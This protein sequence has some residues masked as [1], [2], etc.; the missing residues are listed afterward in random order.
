[1]NLWLIKKFIVAQSNMK[2]QWEKE[3]MAHVQKKQNSNA[4]QKPEIVTQKIKHIF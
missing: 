2:K 1:M 4:L 3:H